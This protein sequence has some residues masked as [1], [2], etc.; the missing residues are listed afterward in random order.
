MDNRIPQ[1][2]EQ[3]LEKYDFH[4]ECL[5]EIIGYI[6][7]S[8]RVL[9]FYRQFSHNTEMLRKLGIN[10]TENKNFEKLKKAENLYS[11]RIKT[12]GMNLRI[13]YTYRNCKLALLL[14]TFHERSDSKDTYRK[15]IPVAQKRMKEMEEEEWH[16][17]KGL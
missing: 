15:Y 17:I 14:C 2:L 8:G 1:S 5:N 7:G 3:L 10:A 6:K 16:I 4:P 9:D 13:I 12:R 11:M